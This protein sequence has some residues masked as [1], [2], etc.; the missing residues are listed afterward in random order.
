[1]NKKKGRDYRVPNKHKVPARQ[2]KKWTL[3]GRAVFNK[4]YEHMVE[5]QGLYIHPKAII[6]ELEIFKTTAWNAS[7]M[8]ADVCSRG[9][10]ILIDRLIIE[11]KGE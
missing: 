3:V 10:R 1:M 11:I 2:W 9:E 8:A 6:E 7:W 5:N 4:T